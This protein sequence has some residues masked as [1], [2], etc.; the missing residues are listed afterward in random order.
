MRDLLVRLR[1]GDRPR[2]RSLGGTGAQ[3]DLRVDFPASRGVGERAGATGHGV[4]TSGSG[5]TLVLRTLKATT[6]GKEDTVLPI[7]P[8]DDR[9]GTKVS[10]IILDASQRS[11]EVSQ[12]VRLARSVEVHLSKPT[13]QMRHARDNSRAGDG[14][15]HLLV[16]GGYERGASSEYNEKQHERQVSNSY[17]EY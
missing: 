4:S 9:G 2:I 10:L 12:V 16:S 13:R 3:I 7:G 1:L 17:A 15:R 5:Q 14:E 8:D 11:G 6:D